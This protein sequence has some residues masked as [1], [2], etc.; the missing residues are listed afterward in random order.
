[1]MIRP[2]HLLLITAKMSLNNAAMD[3]MMNS[4]V[5]YQRTMAI[6]E[7]AAATVMTLEISLNMMKDMISNRPY[8]KYLA[9]NMSLHIHLLLHVLY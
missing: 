6:I 5:A 4:R 3:A 8:G 9:T 7:F 1:M 2:R